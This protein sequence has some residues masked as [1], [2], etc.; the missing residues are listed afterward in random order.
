MSYPL[1]GDSL[2]SGVLAVLRGLARACGKMKLIYKRRGSAAT[3]LLEPEENLVSEPAEYQEPSP[4]PAGA[5][6]RAF[7]ASQAEPAD[8][9][10]YI[11]QR[12]SYGMRL[13]GGMPRSVAGRVILGS[14]GVAVLAIFALTIAGIRQFL[15]HDPRFLITSSAAIAIEGNQHISRADVLAVFAADLERNIFKVPLAERRADLE[16]L[17]WVASATV[18]RLLPG[19]IRVRLVE[20]TP[21]A[22]T[23]NGTQIGLVD[24]SGVLLDMPPDSAGDPHYSF[25]VLT[26]LAPGDSPAIRAARMEVYRRFMAD[27]GTAGSGV[28]QSLSEVDVTNPEDVKAL[29]TSDGAD[30]LVH[31]GDENFLPRYQAFEKHLPEWRTQYP[32]LASADMRYERQVVLEMQPGTRASSVEGPGTA[33][34]AGAPES[35]PATAGS[36]APSAIRKPEPK[37][38]TPP[39]RTSFAADRLAALRHASKSARAT[40]R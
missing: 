22:F 25:P 38:F 40:H 30:I 14:L 5:L 35:H 16:R 7:P 29:V 19:Q 36:A 9:D 11:P 31:F 3:A 13:H 32:H 1:P 2:Y 26:G 24:A 28:T 17:P 15:L 18:M 21:V 20:R 12:G 6:H 8:P 10:A 23:R 34:A 4:A 37:P 27:L 39:H 33:A